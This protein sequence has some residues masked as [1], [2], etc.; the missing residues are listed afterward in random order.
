[1]GLC[2]CQK[3]KVTNLYCFEHNVN[4]CEYCIVSDHERCNVQ[5]YVQWL[6][7]SDYNPVCILCKKLL[8]E[9]PTVRL[10]CY[11][12]FHWNCLDK[13]ASQLPANTAPAGYQCPKCKECIFPPSN[14]VSPVVDGLMQKLETAS[15]ARVGLGQSLIQIDESSSP[16]N[17]SPVQSDIPKNPSLSNLHSTTTDDE[18]NGFVIVK[19]KK[20]TQKV[21]DTPQVAPSTDLGIKSEP[22]SNKI[23]MF[24]TYYKNIS[25]NRANFTESSNLAPEYDPTLGVVLNID[26]LENDI[27]ENKY[28]RRPLFEWLSRLLKSRQ[29]SKKW[30]ITRQKKI[31]FLIIF[32]FIGLFTII[33]IFSRLG[34]ITTEDDPAFDPLNNPN[35]RVQ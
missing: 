2:K 20:P 21:I 15:W 1:M 32:V 27:G 4:V 26:N 23:D 6:Q 8:S 16:E 34:S 29:V 10:I 14:L 7:D 3:R 30:R 31:L 12:V 19:E 9:E 17:P 28:K 18:S 5:S 35:I 25:K 13:Y 33:V 24:P 22:E 11:D